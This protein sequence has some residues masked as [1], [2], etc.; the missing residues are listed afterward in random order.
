MGGVIDFKLYKISDPGGEIESHHL[1]A[2]QTIKELT[3][4]SH[5][6]YDQ[7]APEQG[8]D[9]SQ[10]FRMTAEP[11]DMDGGIRINAEQ[12]FGPYFDLN[13]QSPILLG[14]IPVREGDISVY[15]H[16]YY[17]DHEEAPENVVDLKP[18]IAP[19]KDAPFSTLGFTDAFFEPPHSIGHGESNLEKGKFFLKITR[20]LFGRLDDMI[21]YSWPVD[22]SNYF[23][24]GKEFWGSFF[25]TVYNPSRDWYIGITVSATD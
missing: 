3:E 14:K 25:W 10:M 2:Q 7:I 24:D 13:A 8:R 21:I 17:Y 5:R 20:L 19:Y 18:L 15:R 11:I 9:R 1:I 16:Y 22:C 23:D 12:F 4:D 6:Y